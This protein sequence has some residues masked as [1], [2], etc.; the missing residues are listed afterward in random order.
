MN[1]MCELPPQ[2]RRPGPPS[3]SS[4][5][6]SVVYPKLELPLAKTLRVLAKRE[7]GC[8]GTCGVG[9]KADENE[10]LRFARLFEFRP[11]NNAPFG[12]YRNNLDRREPP[13]RRSKSRSTATSASTTVFRRSWTRPSPRAGRA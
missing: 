11:Y 10:G 7:G 12:L 2:I 9:A 6:S 13:C 1:G 8:K 3:T 4:K 5:C